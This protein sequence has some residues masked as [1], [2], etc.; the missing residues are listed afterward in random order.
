MQ[1]LMNRLNALSCTDIGIPV[2]LILTFIY[3]T[4]KTKLGKNVVLKLDML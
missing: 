4:T 3:F 2:M 1:N